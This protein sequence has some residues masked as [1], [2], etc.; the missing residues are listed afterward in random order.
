[1]AITYNP[2]AG[3]A[4]TTELLAQSILLDKFQ[5]VGDISREREREREREEKRNKKRETG[6]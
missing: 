3:E 2:I 4:E 6:E 5:S 1:V